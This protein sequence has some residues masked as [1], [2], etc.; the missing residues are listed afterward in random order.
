MLIGN[1][2]MN[3]SSL[4]NQSLEIV[5]YNTT[6]S[7]LVIISLIRFVSKIKVGVVK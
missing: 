5:Y 3:P 4:I 7:N 6:L 2:E 1:C